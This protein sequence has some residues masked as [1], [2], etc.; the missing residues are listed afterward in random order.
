[1]KKRLAALFLASV[2]L[3]LSLV[4]TTFARSPTALELEKEA[5]SLEAYAGLLEDLEL[6]DAVRI[7]PHLPVM[8]E[9]YCGA[10]LDERGQLNLML[11]ENAPISAAELM[12]QYSGSI[13]LEHRALYSYNELNR[14]IELLNAK[15]S[16]AMSSIGVSRW[17]LNEQTNRVEVYIA[18][19]TPQKEAAFKLSIYSGNEISFKNADPS[20]EVDWTDPSS[21]ESPVRFDTVQETPA[22]A[23][24]TSSQTILQLGDE[25]ASRGT[26]IDENGQ[27]QERFWY[28]SI[29][30]KVNLGK[31]SNNTYTYSG[32]LTAAHTFGAHTTTTNG[33][34]ITY[35]MS[36]DC[37]IRPDK[38]KEIS[39]RNS[40]KIGEL[41]TYSDGSTELLLGNGHDTAFIKLTNPAFTVEAKMRN[42][43][44][45]SATAEL[46][47]PISTIDPSTGQVILQGASV[48]T[49]GRTTGINEGTVISINASIS[50]D[51]NFSNFIHTTAIV[52]PG[53]SGGILSGVWIPSIQ[54][55]HLLWDHQSHS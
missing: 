53:D 46:S 43:A 33:A 21:S 12:R 8:P 49:C 2:F 38:S 22:Q 5:R 20:E 47:N 28:G 10:Y 19:L 51:P 30:M 44:Y 41:L 1:M 55:K 37:Y 40:I 13:I 6:K 14:V 16:P 42:G 36:N 17:C 50:T 23:F 52:K 39:S 15:R 34:T 24:S 4:T 54:S 32:F 26:R 18:D 25:I 35:T 31:S 9:Y 27:M 3:I 45:I 11:K 29:G 7:S 48:Q